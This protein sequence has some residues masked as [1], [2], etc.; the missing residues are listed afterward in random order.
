MKT[1]IM[2]ALLGLASMRPIAAHSQAQ[3]IEQL[4]LNWE[5][6]SQLKAILKNMYKGYE[7]ISKGYTTVKDISQGNF[8]LHEL[9]FDKLLEIS[10][11]VKKY[12]RIADIIQ[13]QVRI[14]RDY[15]RAFDYFKN[16]GR[17]SIEEIQYMGRVYGNLFGESLRSL[18]ELL[19]VITAK[20]A[21]MSDE[22]RL[23]AIDRIYAE[24]LD[25]FSFLTS[26]NNSTRIL[27][28]QRVKEQA[29]VD[30]SRRLLGR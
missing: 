20:A 9:F 22:E 8:K 27:V 13:Y 3:E 30:L 5:K 23:S 14:V 25:K 26:F 29:E 1:L 10:P 17:F 15:K 6:L 21:R 7:V 2:I 24:M 16:S 4:L 19:I 12:R 18:D 11:A 28:A